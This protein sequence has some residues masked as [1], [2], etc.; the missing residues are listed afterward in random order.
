MARLAHDDALEALLADW[1]SDPAPSLPIAPGGSGHKG[2]GTKKRGR[3][4][5]SGDV[6]IGITNRQGGG[7]RG[8]GGR[9]PVHPG[10]TC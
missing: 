9:A 2:A 10:P 6:E 7:P 5:R 8:E 4:D 1:R 3:P